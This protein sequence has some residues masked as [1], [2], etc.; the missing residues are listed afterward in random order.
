M[1]DLATSS[2]G[3]VVS[4]ALLTVAVVGSGGDLQPSAQ[5]VLAA[6]VPGLL[7]VLFRPVLYPTASWRRHAGVIAAWALVVA[8]VA[9]LT[10]L[11][12]APDLAWRTLRPLLATV[13]CLLV[14]I[15]PVLTLA[16]L[17][18]VLSA[19]AS[20]VSRSAAGEASAWCLT[21]LLVLLASAPLW[22]GP[23]AELALPERPG[24]SEAVLAASPLSPLAVSAGN[25]LLR[26]QWFYQRANLA[27][28]P[29]AYGRPAATLAVGLAAFA[30]LL[31]LLA[32][33]AG[34]GVRRQ[35]AMEP[36]R[37]GEP[38]P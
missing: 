25:D 37:P 36:P 33:V 2:V 18:D 16:T 12:L 30:V 7:A 29:V 15:L 6:A 35:A 20:R 8:T 4:T 28:L 13:A 9:L 31:V 23:A 22:L 14:L 34:P 27:S 5:R 11:V 1:R 21:A 10:G 19:G 26:N 24:V 17:L 38:R 32:Q 3:L